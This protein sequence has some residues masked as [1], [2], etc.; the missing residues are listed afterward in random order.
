VGTD[1]IA[2]V[3]DELRRPVRLRLRG[4]GPA[5]SSVNTIARIVGAL[6]DQCGRS[7]SSAV[8]Y[9]WPPPSKSSTTSSSE[10]MI[11]M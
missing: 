4:S 10:V 3:D 1:P 9:S 7:G 5:L 2:I 11:G 8:E 6:V